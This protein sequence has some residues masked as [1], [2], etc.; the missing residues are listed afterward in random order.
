MRAFLLPTLTALL[1]TPAALAAGG[2]FT[3]TLQPLPDEK[4]VFATVETV[5]KVPARVRTGGT[6]TGL[7][8]REGDTVT[9]GQVI[10]L[11]GDE[12]LG[13]QQSGLEAQIAAARAQLAQAQA[14][15]QRGEALSKN[16]FITRQRLDE[17]RTVLDVAANNLKARTAERAVVGQ[18]MRE[19]QVLAPAAGR[20]LTVP[21]TQGSVVLAGEVVATIARRDYV[22]RLSVPERHAASLKP[23]APV[24]L[25]GEDIAPGAGNGEG[26]IT[27]VYPQISEGRVQAD[28]KVDGLGDYY[29]GQRVRVWID[30]GER[31]VILVPAHHLTTRFGLDFAQVRR[32]DGKVEEVPVQR[33]QP[34]PLPGGLAGVEILSGLRNGDILVQP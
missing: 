7:T 28:A 8:V 25:D 33:G 11:I 19:G 26:A 2:D 16:G 9:A 18:Q 29:V 23:G 30:A 12:K 34:R 32:P 27:L 21:V 17:L 15:L 10:A 3:V 13:L 22:L 4:A 1:L 20:V 5:D 6:I 14:D 31:P 24:R